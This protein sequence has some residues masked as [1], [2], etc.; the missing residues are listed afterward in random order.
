[1]SRLSVYQKSN[2]QFFIIVILFIAAASLVFGAI[3]SFAQED[4]NSQNQA[5]SPTVRWITVDEK[6]FEH[7]QNVVQSKGG[8]FAL[9]IVEKRNGLSV[10]KIDETQL[11]ELSRK[12]HDEFHK[13]GGFI[14][15]ETLDAA[16]LSLEE[17][18]QADAYQQAVEYTINNQTAVNS[19]HLFFIQFADSNPLG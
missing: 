16:R 14:A 2:F 7:I 19:V 15:H 6:E 10:I 12:M 8:D 17:T 9:D 4:K 5:K 3:K 1:M 18:L 11:L 13:C